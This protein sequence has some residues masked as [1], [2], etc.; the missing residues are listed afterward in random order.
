M[1]QIN[2]VSHADTIR[3]TL[4]LAMYAFLGSIAG[5]GLGVILSLILMHFKP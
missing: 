2:T 5:L 1:M 3:G 4:L